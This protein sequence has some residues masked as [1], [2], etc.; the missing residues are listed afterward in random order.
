LDFFGQLDTDHPARDA[1]LGELP[2]HVTPCLGGCD[3]YRQTV[4][5]LVQVSEHDAIQFE[6]W[7]RHSVAGRIQFEKVIPAL[8]HF[9]VCFPCPNMPQAPAFPQFLPNFYLRLLRVLQ[10]FDVNDNISARIEKEPSRSGYIRRC[11]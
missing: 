1:Q 11:G 4:L 7:I 2:F 3:A 5:S 10:I 8:P 9:E 6:D